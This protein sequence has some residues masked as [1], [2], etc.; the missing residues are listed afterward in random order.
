VSWA[1][2]EP[3]AL[4][5]SS[6]GRDFPEESVFGDEPLLRGLFLKG[7]DLFLYGCF[8]GWRAPQKAFVL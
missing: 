7:G 8:K 3:T 1:K 6:T 4:P 5:L 2:T